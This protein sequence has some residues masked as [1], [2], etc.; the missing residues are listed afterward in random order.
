MT[1]ITGKHIPRRTFL[2]GA[3]GAT[4]GLPF[5]DAMVP[6]G[7]PWW[8]T[9]AKIDKP[10]LICL[11]MVHGAAGCHPWGASENLWAPEGLGS[12]FDL[13]PSSLRSL[14]PF[15]DYLTIVS[16]TDVRQA[17]SFGPEEIGGDHFRTTA[18]FL[19][20]SHPRQTEGSNIYAGTSLD[21]IYAKR[22]GQDTPL[23]SMQ[24]TIEPVDQAGGCGFNYSC[25][26][27]DSLSWASPTDPLP[28]IR[29]PR[30]AFDQLFGAGGTPEE[31][32]ARRRTRGSILDLIAERIVEVRQQLGADDGRR[33]D[34]YLENVRELERRIQ[35]TE[36]RN[37]SGDERELPAA[38]AGVPDSF[39][40]HVEMM[41]D[42]QVL[43][44][45]QD[46]T[47]VF[48]L[49]LGRDASSRLY[50]ESGV[51]T[52]FHPLS[53]FGENQ[54]EILKF[55]QLNHYHVGQ[56]PSLLEKLKNTMEGDTHLLDKTAIIYGS[57]MANPNLHS[58]RRCPL[59]VLG[60]ANGQLEGN[61][62]LKAPDGTP[63]ANVMLD[64]MHKIGLDDVESFGDSTGPF[65][66]AQPAG[67]TPATQV[68][69]AR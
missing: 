9:A 33:L 36:Q 55:A 40:E 18:V 56:L 8:E 25:V 39:S 51:N 32:T 16:N 61:L 2:R 49:K 10:R 13:S 53:H 5:L 17:E 52:G 11:E 7:R 37:A 15:R 46:I 27:T 23:P 4:M 59:I 45:Q 67:T 34:Q 42:L 63:M 22:F 64:L 50:P 35:L 41:F 60:K 30:A 68:G 1:Y 47:R 20:Q 38:P 6:A 58:H 65:S 14:E 44:F 43:A 28:M 54:E 3:M 26:Y 12:D 29:D 62:H 69:T 31:R 57:A 24:L 19:T 66:L 21:Q 48:T